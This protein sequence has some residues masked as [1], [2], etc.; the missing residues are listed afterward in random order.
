MGVI[1]C[2][3]NL[4]AFV[5]V[6]VAVAASPDAGG[7][8]KAPA[9]SSSHRQG[10]QLAG[11][12][13]CRE[14]HRRFFELWAPSHHG[15]A[16]Q[17]YSSD[18]ARGQ[19]TAHRSEIRI[20]KRAYQAHIAVEE[21]WV[22]ERG[23]EGEKRLPMAHVLGGKNVF[24]FL[25]A[26]EGGR[27]QTLP[28][29]YDVRRR[30]W[31]DTAASGVR[32]SSGQFDEPLHWTDREYTFNTSCYNCHVSQ[33]STNYD[34]TTDTYRT[35]WAEPGINC[36]TCHGHGGEHVAVCRDIPE[37]AT[38]EDLKIISMKSL[39]VD[40]R[41][42]ACA[43]CHAKMVPMTTTFRPGERFFDHFDL[44][45]LEDSDFYPDGRDLGENYTYTA[46]RI[47][48]CVSAGQLDCV[49]CHTSS[50]RFR[51]QDQPDRSCLP[52]HEQRVQNVSAHSHH[53]SDS[54]GSR[55][56]ACHLPMTE[57]A[58]MKRSDH[59]M[60][61]PMPAATVRFGSPNACN[62]CHA[63]KD[64]AW[65]DTH[66]R[67]WHSSDY[68]APELYRAGLVEAARQNDWSR[69]A[70]ILTY[71]SNT[72]RNEVFA[73]GLLRLLRSCPDRCKVPTAVRVLKDSSPLVRAAAA[74]ALNGS[75][76]R[77]ATAALIEA[78]RDEHRLVRIRAAE[79]L[80]GM[81]RELLAS[82]ERKAVAK[83]TEELEAAMGARPDDAAS[84]YSLGNL[85]L[86][87]G[88]L[89]Q[90][91]AC[92]EQS[93]KLDPRRIEPLVNASIAY[94]LQGRN[95][96]A[97][98]SLRQALQ[99]DPT[100]AVANLNLGMLL[101]EMSRIEE[102]EAAFRAARRADP[103]SAEAAYNL[104]VIVA[105]DRVEEAITLC[106]EA[107]ELRSGEP[108]F[109]YTLAFY[110]RESGRIEEAVQTLRRLLGEHPGSVDGYMLLG[111]IMERQRRFAEAIDV[112]REA[113]DNEQL[114]APVRALF[115]ARIRELRTEAD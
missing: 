65:A 112:Y 6:A 101:G 53:A 105:G 100:C 84:H 103:K 41:N 7:G 28:V 23:P 34:P 16:M 81:P 24:Y 12:V 48:R 51:F 86:S 21:G 35:S 17:P 75:L 93:R 99:L 4:V 77:E 72:G 19:L 27:L 73:T 60:R 40:E 55:C 18:L 114:S 64:A 30:E 109:A 115:T 110:L 97:E 94:K 76:T 42:A 113:A 107:V 111:D 9:A 96:K 47:S 46:W 62:I 1:R 25:T 14:C 79:A 90:A 57:F 104:A 74:D 102:A 83:A 2:A 29:A 108:K 32:H 36:E 22:L 52:C 67:T 37:G 63:D 11:S 106:R 5:G 70:D 10:R 31:F 43:A 38:P 89:K 56:I 8:Y 87:W 95:D 98:A 68:Q 59:S 15:L 69:L 45:T 33:L 20:G 26:I 80:A 44:V 50:G 49:H 71:L 13:S 61:P 85:H 54:T 66:V 88:E 3:A 82:A 91:L 39:T 58:R 78:A 92:F